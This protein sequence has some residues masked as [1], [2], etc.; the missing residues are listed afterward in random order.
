MGSSWSSDRGRRRPDPATE[1]TLVQF[2]QDK[3]LDYQRAWKARVQKGKPS[4]A[5]RLAWWEKQYGLI[6]R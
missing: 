4:D 5:E 3:R 6:G 1:P 2:Q